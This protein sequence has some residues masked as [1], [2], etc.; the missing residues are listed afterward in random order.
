[1]D[2][3]RVSTKNTSK[4][5]KSRNYA[6]SEVH[7][8]TFTPPMVHTVLILKNTSLRKAKFG[9]PTGQKYAKATI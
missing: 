3:E 5:N 2:E 1:M 8:H 7:T 6:L 9:R 4:T